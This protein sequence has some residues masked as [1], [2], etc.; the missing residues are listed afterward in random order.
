MC[1][2]TFFIPKGLDI[3]A[4]IRKS[5]PSIPHFRKEKVL[6]ILD[7]VAR[8]SAFNHDV[9]DDE[10]G[11]VPINAEILRKNIGDRYYMYLNWLVDCKV[12]LCNNHFNMVTHESRRYKYVPRYSLGLTKF[13]MKVSK[14]MANKVKE[15]KI[16]I[17][18]EALAQAP[19][20]N[21][22]AE[23][24]RAN[25]LFMKLP[26]SQDLTQ[27]EKQKYNSWMRQAMPDV[28]KWYD[29]K[30]LQIDSKLANRY[31]H[32]LWQFRTYN[33][34]EREK[35]WNTKQKCKT[36][37]NPDSQLVGNQYIIYEMEEQ[38]YN[39]HFDPNIFRLH[40]SLTYMKKEMRPA[41]SW[42]EHP[43]VGVDI[44]NSQPYL[45]AALFNPDFWQPK[46][47]G[48]STV[49]LQD[50]PYNSNYSHL[51]PIPDIITL[52]NFFE[53]Q[54]PSDVVLFKQIVASG[55]FYERLRDLLTPPKSGKR[56]TREEMKRLM[57][58]VLF[59]DNM[60]IKQGWAKSKRDFAKLFPN[61]CALIEL[62]QQT[63]APNLPCLLQRL[64][65]HLMFSCILPRINAELPNTPV[66]T[67]HDGI[68]TLKDKELAVARILREELYYATN[69]MPSYKFE[70]WDSGKLMY[71]LCCDETLFESICEHYY[72][73]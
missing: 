52:C 8:I 48:K 58:I 37:K 49:T 15:D 53:S 73:W 56:Y 50:L 42:K 54:Q 22:F 41:V 71:D 35:R 72:S 69:L 21:L 57:F 36:E 18:D 63:G 60:V 26:A 14:W 17:T 51:Y 44:S 25:P 24:P 46:G 64:E 9:A 11:Y 67:I 10:G 30:G 33:Y 1:Q 55:K 27:D 40:S 66:F 34:V 12:L 7:V 28:F 45:L 13:T 20:L 70:H 68:I 47:L 19:N 31:N 38:R 61:V 5:P 43:L 3:D 29:E 59:T 2:H 16:D 39:C 62:I 32:S 4:L 65:S 6:Y 23:I